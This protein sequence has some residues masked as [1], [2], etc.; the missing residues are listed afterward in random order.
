MNKPGSEES[1]TS[2]VDCSCNVLG[3]DPDGRALSDFC[4]TFGLSQLVK[5]ATRV[6]EKSESL[7]D[8][9]LTTNEEIIYACDVIPSASAI[10]VW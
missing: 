3:N 7:I 8:V 4:S 9:A 1:K 6:T 2:H 10:T 5:T